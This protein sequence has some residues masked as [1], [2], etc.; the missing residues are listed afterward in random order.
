MTGRPTIEVENLSC[1]RGGIGVLADVS[2]VV[3]SGRCAVLGGENGAGKSTLLR[4]LSGLLTPTAGTFSLRPGGEANRHFVGHEN[5]V[6]PELTVRDQLDFVSL[7]AGNE[8]VEDVART[9]G[10]AHALDL[11]AYTLSTGQKRRLALAR[12]LVDERPIWL[13]D[14]PTAGLDGSGRRLFA[15]L[16]LDHMDAGG[17]ALV[18]THDE[19]DLPSERAT[20]LDLSRS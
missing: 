15:D 19:I 11:P 20:L 9:V 4:V 18:A 13:L 14:E 7:V 10:V 17:V 8:G 12:L 16:L 1:E 6:K 2:F 3:E 5:A